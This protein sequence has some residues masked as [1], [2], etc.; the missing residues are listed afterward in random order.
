MKLRNNE[1]KTIEQLPPG[2]RSVSKFA[3]DHHYTTAHIYKMYRNGQFK[4]RFKHDII[5]Y[6]GY[7]FVVPLEN[8]LN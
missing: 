4:T 7:N 6:E 5:I 3:K 1:Y 2:A 8:Q